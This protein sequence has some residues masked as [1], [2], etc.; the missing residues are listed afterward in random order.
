MRGTIRSP[1]IAEFQVRLCRLKQLIDH[2]EK[3]MKIRIMISVI[4]L[5]ASWS[6]LFGIGFAGEQLSG[7][8]IQKLL[9]GKTVT[10]D[11]GDN[12][13]FTKTYND[14]GT[15]YLE[16]DGNRKGGTWRVTDSEYCQTKKETE[17]CFT[18]EKEGNNVFR[19][20]FPDGTLHATFSVQ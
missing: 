20:L 11:A 14:D 15:F 7:P 13:L 4:S 5:I 19:M 18:I 9:A 10:G 1:L 2:M 6:L 16:V 12:I 3:F 17:T 8:D